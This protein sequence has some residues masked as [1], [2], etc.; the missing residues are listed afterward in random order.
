MNRPMGF[1]FCKDRRDKRMK[2]SGRDDKRRRRSE[3]GSNSGGDSPPEQK[4]G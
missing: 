2:T 3:S 1:L 4:N